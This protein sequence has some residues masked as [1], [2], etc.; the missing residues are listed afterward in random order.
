[1]AF[2]SLVGIAT[3]IFFAGVHPEVFGNWLAAAPIVA[4]GAPLAFIIVSLIGRRPTLVVVAVLCIFQFLWTMQRSFGEV[5]RRW[6]GCV[7]CR[8]VA[9]HRPASNGCGR[10][11]TGWRAGR[12]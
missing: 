6:G 4:L 7:G 2:T 12:P 10:S 1:M 9:V 8:R 5:G 11:A 3:K